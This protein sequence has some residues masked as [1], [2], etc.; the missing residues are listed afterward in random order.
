MKILI[1][2]DDGIL[3]NGI[4]AL[5][6]ALAPCHDVYVV[7]PDRERSAAG[8]SLTLHTPI[9]VEEVPPKYG[10]KRCWMTS[11]T[12]GDCVKMA[13]TAIL[14]E[15]EKPDLVISGLNHG[16]NLG[17]DIIYSGTVNCALEGAMLGYPAIATSLTTMRNDY[18]DFK[19]RHNKN[20]VKKKL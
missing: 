18:E 11:G 6:E 1:S 12:P 19:V 15:S 5:I 10:A 16:P 20:T 13:I 7:A 17:I 14:D 3:A 2:N 9:R 8:H 4:R